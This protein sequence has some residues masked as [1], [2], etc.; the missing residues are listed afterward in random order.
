MA[1]KVRTK[2]KEPVKKISVKQ[3]SVR[4]LPKKAMPQ[5]SLEQLMR[6][7]EEIEALLSSLEDA[8]SEAS[9]LEADY[10]DIKS[11]NEKKLGEINKKIEVLSKSQP[12]SAPDE[13]PIPTLARAA[14][15][16]VEIPVIEET[17]E[18]P[19]AGTRPKKD[20]KEKPSAAVGQDDI[21]K[22][23]IDLAEKIKQMVE[24]I[25]AKVTDK[26]LME[27]RNSFAKFDAEVDKM[28]A[29]VE[30]VKESRRVDDDK[31]QRIVEGLAEVRTMLYGREAS[32]KEQEI[33]TEK[34]IDIMGKLEP[35]KILLEMG[36]RDKEISNQALRVNKLEET[37]REFGEMLKRIEMLLRN[38]G[39]LEH[40]IKISTEASQ[41]MMEMQ[42]IQRSSQKMSDKIQGMY[43]E[44]SKRMEEFML[45]RAKQDRVDDMLN[46]VLK[47]LDELNTKVAYFVTKDDM[48]SFRVS[49]QSSIA[50]ASAYSPSGVSDETA[51]QKE[52]IGMLLKTLEDEFKSRIIS[53]EE[54]EKMRNA[55]LAKLKD[56]GVKGDAR[57]VPLP[58]VKAAKEKAAP[59]KAEKAKE[60]VLTKEV[61]SRNEMLLKDLEDT[62]K[63]GFIS[64]EAYEKTKKMI[65]G[66]R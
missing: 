4:A 38:I 60:P 45:Y 53:K 16:R 61:K 54:Y 23:Q 64:K 19:P 66:K 40:V 28:K 11:K 52:E 39:S 24:D 55:N 36:K 20:K 58:P 46:D 29:Q 47:N 59:V 57:P 41:K 48:D 35:E 9:I 27:M 17:E 6:Q 63:K 26:D 32:T 44:L 37:S 2:K 13:E 3:T 56:L 15:P 62:Y 25:G 14:R 10:D 43:A 65:L 30:A 33:K 42:N 51:S 8:Y 49:M 34:M 50:A 7:K 22:L 31:I 21:E 12:E 5:E 18:A 1:K